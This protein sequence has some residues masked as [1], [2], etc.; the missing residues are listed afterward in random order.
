M[1]KDNVAVKLLKSL[2][3]NW[4][5]WFKDRPLAHTTKSGPGRRHREGELSP[6]HPECNAFGNKLARKALRGRAS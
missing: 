4:N 2:G 3:V 6:D 1:K 5:G